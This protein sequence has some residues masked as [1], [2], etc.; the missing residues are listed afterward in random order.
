MRALFDIPAD[1]PR[2]AAR[3]GA[4][5]ALRERFYETVSVAEAGDNFVVQLDGKPAHT[6]AGAVLAAPTPELAR[7]LAAEWQ[8][9]RARIDPATMPLTRLANTIID[10]VAKAPGPV[11]AELAKYLSSDL[12]FYRAEAPQGLF[13]NQNRDWDPILNWAEAAFGARFVLQTGIVHVAQ[14]PAALASVCA[15]IPADPWR[16]GALHVLTT[17]TGSAL[18]ALA[19]ARGFLS[20]DDAWR[21]AHVDEDW[22]ILQWGADAVALERRTARFAEFSAAAAVLRYCPD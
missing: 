17:L 4:R 16:L 14:P 21:A 10:G 11:A 7:A 12:L 22:N 1:D 3:R 20:A 9:Q 13:E 15:A 2:E 6:P 18:L 5:P 8:A 19:V